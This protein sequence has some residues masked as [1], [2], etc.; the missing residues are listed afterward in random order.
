VSGVIQSDSDARNVPADEFANM[1]THAVGI[2]MAAIGAVWCLSFND[3][4]TIAV[5]VSILVYLASV[6]FV[7]V[8]STLSHAVHRQPLRDKMR[9]WDQASIYVMIAGTYTPFAVVY[10]GSWTI[11]FLLFLWLA[12]AFGFYS[13]L[14]AKHRINTMATITYLALGWVPAIPFAAMVPTNCLIVMALGGLAYSIGT[15]FLMLDRRRYFHSVWHL[16]VIA[17]ATL[18][19]AGVYW[20]VVAGV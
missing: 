8:C 1:L 20:Y 3:L 15:I 6:I 14:I 17:A 12:A 5:R 18:H 16:L 2:A 4:S 19:F 13:K 10:G 9:A 11:P 7:F